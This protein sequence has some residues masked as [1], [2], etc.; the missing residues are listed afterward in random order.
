MSDKESTGLGGT[1]G[2]K[3]RGS[4]IS[5]GH[6]FAQEIIK[7]AR[8]T[9]A[10]SETGRLLLKSCEMGRI[11]INVIKGLGEPGFS[12]ESRVIYLQAA[13]KVAKADPKLVL[14]LVKALREADQDL[15]GHKAPDPS[16]DIMHYAT[17]MHGKN[18][19]AIVYV[20]K[21]VKDMVNT[22]LF[23]NFIDAL[24]DLGYKKVYQAYADNGSKEDIYKAYANS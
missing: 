1:F 13:G 12:P 5:Y 10:E 3:T 8:E 18:M 11:P 6:P 24:D 22:S 19:E 21:F 17:V 14:Q 23:P 4:Q 16:K 15:L 2:G 9:I 20:C 7:S